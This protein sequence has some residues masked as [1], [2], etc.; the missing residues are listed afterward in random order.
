MSRWSD[1][2]Y[3]SDPAMDYFAIITD[4]IDRE[5]NYLCIPEKVFHRAW[6]LNDI[7]AAIEVL[8]LFDAYVPAC[9]VFL[10]EPQTLIRWR[11]ALLPVWDGDWENDD[12][13]K[14]LPCNQRDYRKQHRPGIIAMFDRLE[15]IALHWSM[16]GKPGVQPADMKPLHPD[17]QLPFFS[18]GSLFIGRLRYM[19]V[20]E[21]VYGLTCRRWAY[22]T[23]DAMM[24]AVD[25]LG[26]LCEAYAISP[27]ID[28]QSVNNWRIV[29]LQRFDDAYGEGWGESDST[30]QNFVD[31]FDRLEAMAKQYPPYER[32]GE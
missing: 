6:W 3:D 21:I 1:G 18:R 26:F 13:D 23:D 32:W 8:L 4:A 5:I 15:S 24:V 7:L 28:V 31:S 30:Y 16:V 19:R 2:I 9:T 11:E 14:N 17:Y 12:Y 29:I 27:G 22:M 10:R 20:Q 25:V